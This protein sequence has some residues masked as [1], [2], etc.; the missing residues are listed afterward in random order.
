VLSLIQPIIACTWLGWLAASYKLYVS[1][2]HYLALGLAVWLIYTVDGLL[3]ARNHREGEP[4][5]PRRGFLRRHAGWFWLLTF[6]GSGCLLGL[7]LGELGSGLFLSGIFL[8]LLVLFYLGHAQNLRKARSTFLPKEV[9]GGVLFAMGVGLVIIEAHGRGAVGPVSVESAVMA[10]KGGLLSAVLWL[11]QSIL[12]LLLTIFTDGAVVL[13]ALLCVANTLLTARHEA[14]GLGDVTSAKRL[15]PGLVALGPVF[16]LALALSSL[17]NLTIN[18]SPE[19]RP[20]H[21][22]VALSAILMFTVHHFARQ[23]RLSGPLAAFL[24]DVALLAPLALFPFNPPV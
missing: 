10:V 13:F 1:G 18:R 21:G 24:L 15:A 3:D 17:V 19:L 5:S 2:W 9:F 8:G 6:V 4:L 20:V 7:A 16:T 22:A 11:V 23:H 14:V 12:F